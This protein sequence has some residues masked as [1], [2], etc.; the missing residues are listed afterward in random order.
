MNV[1]MTAHPPEFYLRIAQNFYYFHF[2]NPQFLQPIT[3]YM[4][5]TPTSICY[6]L[7]SS[8]FS[9]PRLYANWKASFIKLAKN[10]R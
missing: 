1:I 2:H 3:A 10:V 6:N 9:I 5:D 7:T 8:L 4:Q